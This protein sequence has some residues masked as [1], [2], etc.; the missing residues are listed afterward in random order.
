MMRRCICIQGSHFVRMCHRSY[1]PDIGRNLSR[2]GG[3]GGTRRR[4][5]ACVRDEERNDAVAEG[6]CNWGSS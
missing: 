1:D 6:F 5:D 2:G 3:R 4:G